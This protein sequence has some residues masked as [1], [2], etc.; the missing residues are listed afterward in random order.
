MADLNFAE[1]A[2][3]SIKKVMADMQLKTGGLFAL[4]YDREPV[5]NEEQTLRNRLN[6][7]NLT[8]DF[9][10]LCVSKLSGLQSI[11]M[12]VF[13]GL[14]QPVV[15]AEESIPNNFSPPLRSQFLKDINFLNQ[16]DDFL[17]LSHDQKS[18]FL[19][20][21]DDLILK[22]FSN[23]GRLAEA[24]HDCLNEYLAETPD[25]WFN[26]RKARAFFREHYRFSE[27]YINAHR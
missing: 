7:G 17:A 27:E 18:D 9:I 26:Q 21:L 14:E 13:F 5:G 2:R 20:R 23:P 4:L 6:R 24:E 25:V 11:S 3:D 15:I 8:S 16:S 10:G 12:S 1:I 19:L 22:Y